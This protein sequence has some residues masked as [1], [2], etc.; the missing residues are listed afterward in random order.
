MEVVLNLRLFHWFLPNLSYTKTDKMH[1]KLLILCTALVAA[2]AAAQPLDY[3][4]R[5]TEYK[6]PVTAVGISPDSLWVLAG[7]EDGTLRIYGAETGEEL[8]AFDGVAGA[9]IF[10]IAMSPKMDVIFLAAGN[11]IQLCDTTGTIINTWSHNKNTIWSMDIDRA[12]K[13]IVCAEVNKTFLLIDVFEG[14]VAEEMRAHEDITLAVA[15]SPDGRQIASGSSDKTVLIW[16]LQ[17]KEVT[18]KLQGHSGNIY[19]VEFS[20]NGEYVAS[21]SQ[22]KSVRIWNIAENRLVHLLK[23]HQDMVLEV[24]FSPDGH[25][26]LSASA[27]HAIKL[28]DIETGEQLYAYL[29]NQG[30]I[31]DIAFLPGGKQFISAGMDGKLTTWELHPEL[32]VMKY[33]SKEYEME[34]SANPLFLP[35]QKGEKKAG[36]EL[37][38]L[39]AE[40]VKQEILEKYYARYL[41][42][43]GY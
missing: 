38:L 27:D 14:I 18:G 10:D 40:K 22:D 23:G 5:S 42:N 28:W 2:T 8:H 19:D 31:P 20:P 25:Y 9:A 13:Q 12:G 29:E 26:L 33:F 35:R 1:K 43:T 30:S 41:D 15:F 11:R 37:R 7:F 24:E 3:I 36:Y 39:E 4:V 32:F 21:A 34:L 17:T 6:T 16:N